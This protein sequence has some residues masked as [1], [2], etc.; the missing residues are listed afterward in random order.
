MLGN[1]F[2]CSVQHEISIGFWSGFYDGPFWILLPW[3]LL[4]HKMN[5][6]N[7]QSKNGKGYNH[8]PENIFRC[9]LVHFLQSR[10]RY[11]NEWPIFALPSE[12]QPPL[13]TS[14]LMRTLLLN[15]I[16]YWMIQVRR[17][18]KLAMAAT[19]FQAAR[20][21]KC[22]IWVKLQRNWSKSPTWQVADGFCWIWG[23]VDYSRQSGDNSKEHRYAK[24]A[25]CGHIQFFHHECSLPENIKIFRCSKSASAEHFMLYL[26]MTS[27]TSMG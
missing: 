21:E 4:F 25:N 15:F 11:Q 13:A 20:P 1:C 17:A 24:T 9:I 23:S 18:T 27:K 6:D 22:K 26:Y 3:P 19:A 14:S 12:F 8:Q 2:F 5:Y 10:F 16:E 7:I